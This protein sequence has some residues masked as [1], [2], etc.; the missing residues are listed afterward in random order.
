MAAKFPTRE[1]TMAWAEEHGASAP[2]VGDMAPDF[3]LH[4][5]RGETSVRLSSFQ[6]D[7]PVALI[8]GSFT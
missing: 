7:R 6:G 3:E 8:F 5:V 1:S 2:A 4:D